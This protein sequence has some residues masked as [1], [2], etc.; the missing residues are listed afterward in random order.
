MIQNE[1]LDS[2]NKKSWINELT[3]DVR[4]A[5]DLTSIYAD[6]VIQ[7]VEDKEFN[8]LDDAIAELKT[9]VNLTASETKDLQKV[10]LAK[11]EPDVYIAEQ[12]I[13]KLSKQNLGELLKLATTPC[14]KCTNAPCDCAETISSVV[15]RAINKIGLE[16]LA[17][18]FDAMKEEISTPAASTPATAPE[19]VIDLSKEVGNIA[20]LMADGS[21]APEAF[22]KMSKGM[23]PGFQAYLDK[24]K[25]DKEGKGEDKKD[26]ETSKTDDKKDEKE[27]SYKAKVQ[28]WAEYLGKKGYFQGSDVAV[29]NIV[30][31]DPNKLGY[32]S[33]DGVEYDR[34]PM[35]VPVGEDS[36]PW[37]QKWFEGAANE[38]KKEM[39]PGGT[40][41]ELKK[42]WQ[43]ARY[44]GA[45]K[46]AREAKNKK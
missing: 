16:S 26:D 2:W 23:N 19:S 35:A 18:A 38:T 30:S 11:T 12:N 33:K 34:K 44:M 10:V 37:E 40:D 39:L 7:A 5:K 27:A 21:S 25:K 6:D 29:D 28:K 8:N 46:R 45:V 20:E 32:G 17:E 1:H 14:Q 42:K 3:Q 15:A 4:L 22:Q 41:L 13:R 31:N 9:R 24:K 43:R 36:R